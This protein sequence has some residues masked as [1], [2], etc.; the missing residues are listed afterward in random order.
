MLECLGLTNCF[1]LSGNE[2]KKLENN[3]LNQESLWRFGLEIILPGTKVPKWF[4]YTSK[5]PTTFEPPSE[6]EGEEAV[7]G[8]ECCFEIPLNLQV[9]T[10]GLALCIVVEASTPYDP[11]VLIN[12]GKDFYPNLK[13]NIEATHVWFKLVDLDEQQRDTCQVIFQFLEGSHIKSWRVHSLLLNQDELLPL[14]L[15]STSSLEKRPRPSGPPDYEYDQLQQ[16]PSLSSE[17][18]DDHTKRRHIDLNVPV[19]IED[20]QEQPSTSKSQSVGAIPLCVWWINFINVG[21]KAG[22]PSYK[23][24]IN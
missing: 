19:E 6:N 9:E 18:A 11:Y 3:L 13:Y 21:D 5:H 16:W 1:R 17:L 23:C 10:S 12:G 15:G 20:E 7:R 22:A 4:S 8:S 14:S 24:V 2:V